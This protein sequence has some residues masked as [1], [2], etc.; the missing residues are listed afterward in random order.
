VVGL[1]VTFWMPIQRNRRVWRSRDDGWELTKFLNPVRHH[2][3]SD[4]NF[5]DLNLILSTKFYGFMA[6]M[7]FNFMITHIFF[8][9]LSYNFNI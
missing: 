8:I 9:K 6:E 1:F 2:L 5:S 4:Q 7:P 3:D